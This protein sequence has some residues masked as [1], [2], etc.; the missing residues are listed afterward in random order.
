MSNKDLFLLDDTLWVL[1]EPTGVAVY[2]FDFPSFFPCRHHQPKKVPKVENIPT[3]ENITAVA[4]CGAF[5]V[6]D[7]CVTLLE[8]G[9]NLVFIQHINSYEEHFR[10]TLLSHWYSL[11]KDLTPRSK[12]YDYSPS[13][14]EVGTEFGWPL[15]MKG[16]RQTSHHQRALSLI[17]GPDAFHEAMQ[18]SHQDRILNWQPIVIRELVP[19]RPVEDPFPDRIPS[20]FEFR[21]FWWRGELV[22]YGRYWWEGKP[23][24]WTEQEKAEG[25]AVAKEAATR[26]NI[27]FLVIDIAQTVEGR[28]IVIECN[29]GQESG[30]AGASPLGIWHSILTIERRLPKLSHC[31]RG[32]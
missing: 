12:C 31:C 30:Y 20:S 2:D 6:V 28:W 3:I 21:T 32:N 26:L 24:N 1:T 11:I 18:A 25:L 19:L 29:D 5:K 13:V 23:Y 15:F 16:N 8:R 14:A 4:R 17:S 22:G 9:E 10:C 27:P 7:S